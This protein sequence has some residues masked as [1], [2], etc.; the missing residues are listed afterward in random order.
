MNDKKKE[1]ERRFIETAKCENTL[2]VKKN[3]RRIYEIKSGWCSVSDTREQDVTNP[4]FAFQL[5]YIVFYLRGSVYVTPKCKKTA[6]TEL[7]VAFFMGPLFLLST[8][9]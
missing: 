8:K 7:D 9:K 2:N 3:L 5:I 4:Y 1:R 6:A